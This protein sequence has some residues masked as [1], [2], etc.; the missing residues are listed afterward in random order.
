MQ[1]IRYGGCVSEELFEMFL[2]FLPQLF[3]QSDFVV[4]RFSTWVSSLRSASGRLLNCLNSLFV[5]ILQVICEDFES[6]VCDYPH[7]SSSLQILRKS[8]N[9]WRAFSESCDGPRDLPSDPQLAELALAIT[10]SSVLVEAI[11]SEFCAFIFA[12]KALKLKELAF[13]MYSSNPLQLSK[14]SWRWNMNT[15]VITHEHF[16]LLCSLISSQSPLSEVIFENSVLTTLQLGKLYDLFAT[17]QPANLPTVKLNCQLHLG[18]IAQNRVESVHLNMAGFADLALF[19]ASLRKNSSLTS[20]SMS[21]SDLQGFTS[22]FLDIRP[23]FNWVSLARNVRVFSITQSS[24]DFPSFR[25][26]AFIFSSSEEICLAAI[27]LSDDMIKILSTALSRNKALKVLDISRNPFTSLGFK[28][29]MIS[30]GENV[31]LKHLD[32]SECKQIE[33]TQLHLISQLK[34]LQVLKLC[35]LHVSTSLLSKLLRACPDVTMLGVDESLQNWSDQESLGGEQLSVLSLKNNCMLSEASLDAILRGKR[36][37]KQLYVDGC[38]YFSGSTLRNVLASSQLELLSLVSCLSVSFH[39]L[40]TSQHLRT[41]ALSSCTSSVTDQALKVVSENFPRLTSLN[42]HRCNLITDKGLRFLAEGC[43]HLT[44]LDLSYC[45]AVSDNGIAHVASH[46]RLLESISL[47][48]SRGS[49][50]KELEYL[51]RGCPS[52]TS[53]NISNVPGLSNYGVKQIAISSPYIRHLNL[54]RGPLDNSLDESIA[55]LLSNVP[56][57]EEIFLSDCTSLTDSVIGDLVRKCKKLKTLHVYG[58]HGL[59]D[60]CLDLIAEYC[61][62][63]EVINIGNVVKFTDVGVM[64]MVSQCHHLREFYAPYCPG[65]SE[66]SMVAIAQNERFIEIIDISG[67]GKITDTGIEHLRRN[68]KILKTLCIKSTAE[69]IS[70]DQISKLRQEGIEVIC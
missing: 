38:A 28:Q 17:A 9:C 18:E 65:I 53:I 20:I 35:G 70:K 67:S 10:T 11:G 13:Q 6:R 30:L 41:L 19:L 46:C 42:L 3:L 23:R 14:S 55:I 31:H 33:E 7:A 45:G 29:L 8:L 64:S 26:L 58:C 34:G 54:S 69:H 56:L 63:L 60:M 1:Y 39:D 12:R 21:N 4:Y 62:Q 43:H 49:A 16:D 52:L 32:I 27:S 25:G 24:I 57:L 2:K 50:D 44:L 48:F 68:C 36:S 47:W 5:R 61:Q 51:S 59:T 66:L 37:L 40:T 22:S 15:S